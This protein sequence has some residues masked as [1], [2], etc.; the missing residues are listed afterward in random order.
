MPT[1]QR[2]PILLDFEK[3]L[4]ELE[5]RISQIKKLAEENEVDVSAQLGQLQTRADQLRHEIFASLTPAQR[6]QVARHP[7]RPS[8]LDYIQSISDEWL[9]LHGD[10]ASGKND[11]A[12][13]GGIARFEG[14]P[15]VMLGHQKGRDTKD[16][17]A[18]N[19]G[20]ASPGGYRK[21]MRL[22]RHANQFNMPVF[23]FIDTPGAYPGYEAEEMG[24]GE[25][26]A[27]NLREM[28]SLEVPI[29]CTVIGEGGSGGALGIGVGD[30]LM[31][32]EHAVYTVASPEACAAILWKDA[33]RAAE[34]A[35]ALKITAADLQNL[36]ILDVML[37]EPLGGAHA[38]PLKAT[39]LLKSALRKNL[40]ELLAITS[41]ERRELRYQKFRQ[42]G[43]FAEGGQNG[44]SV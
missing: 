31:M 35:E 43:V 5:D 32:F 18:R 29:I 7:R 12:L 4:V 26:I 8:T 6:L 33:G 2:K 37:P 10:R 25:A 42:I 28:F 14:Q 1:T 3:P 19:F 22:M 40:K 11:P 44:Q 36:G 39:E 34:A 17:M 16:N 20:M 23:T 21:A 27:Y 41:T 30:R 38:D 24:Q 15:V 9:E 13:V